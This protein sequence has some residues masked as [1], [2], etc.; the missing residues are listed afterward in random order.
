MAAQHAQITAESNYQKFQQSLATLRSTE[1]AADDNARRI[2]D[3][4]AVH[5]QEH[6]VAHQRLNEIQAGFEN[7][8]RQVHY[9]RRAENQCR[10]IAEHEHQKATSALVA[11]ARAEAEAQAAGLYARVEAREIGRAHV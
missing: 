5:R 11:E 2:R 1:Q 7:E 3:E 6:L 9:L 10:E 8:S 4:V